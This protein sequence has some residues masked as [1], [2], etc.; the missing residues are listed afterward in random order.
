MA[1]KKNIPIWKNKVVVV[2]GVFITIIVG[3]TAF[4]TLNS[5]DNVNGSRVA[6]AQT[7]S[8]GISQS[9]GFN[10]SEKYNEDLAKFNNEKA[11]TAKQNGE[12]YISSVSGNDKAKS[13]AEKQVIEIVESPTPEPV[14]IA[15]PVINTYPVN[16]NRQEQQAI[17]L[18]QQEL[19]NEKEKQRLRSL[20]KQQELE[21]Q[22]MVIEANKK[23]LMERERQINNIFASYVVNEKSSV[24]Q[25]KVFIV[26]P[27]EKAVADK[28]E[29]VTQGRD[30]INSDDVNT[31]DD[32]LASEASHGPLK[33]G[34][35][36][37]AQNKIA[38]NSDF[39]VQDA[40]VAEIISPNP[41]INGI[42]LFGQFKSVDD[43]MVVSFNSY[44]TPNG[45]S[46]NIKA[47]AISEDD[48]TTAVKSRVDYH[49]FERWA[50]FFAGS[51]LE[52]AS[53]VVQL[54]ANANSSVI[55]DAN[56]APVGSSNPGY[57]YSPD[58]EAVVVLGKMAEKGSDLLK[59]K[60][61][62]KPT[63][64]LNYGQTMGVIVL[65]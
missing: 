44:I 21:R 24:K 32:N 25:S 29:V 42:K 57:K 53:E 45:K 39:S 52:G 64:F 61:N 13:L 1:D 63:V 34:D 12:T 40:V 59:D 10:G 37:Y 6:S 3:F 51:M 38:I 26:K 5:S 43:Q 54:R 19:E 8:A 17:M 7:A 22:K 55:Y 60:F 62:K 31:R 48:V 27:Y 35:V 20:A 23:A 50:S 65:N 56:G 18:K 2:S 28:Q 46:Y 36:Y 4:K 14:K 58:E 49:S 11:E 9:S 33:P 41:E 15:E 16:D 47:Y 30:N